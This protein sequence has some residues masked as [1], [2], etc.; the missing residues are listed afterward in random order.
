MSTFHPEVCGDDHRRPISPPDDVVRHL[1][2]K[3][4]AIR[5]RRVVDDQ[6][7][8]LDLLVVLHQ[9]GPVQRFRE[10]K[11]VCNTREILDRE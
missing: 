11:V 2:R 9:D 6:D 1:A 5:Q 8:V 7:R 3:V 10:R 4:A